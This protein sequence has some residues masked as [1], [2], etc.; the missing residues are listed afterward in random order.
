MKEKSALNLIFVF[1]GIALIVVTAVFV[2]SL[3]WSVFLYFVSACMIITAVV[4]MA[5]ISISIVT[6]FVA[7]FLIFGGWLDL[8]GS[9]S[10]IIMD[11]SGSLFW[12]SP[13]GFVATLIVGACGEVF[14]KRAYLKKHRNELFYQNCEEAGVVGESAAD[15]ARMKLVAEQMRIT[16]SEKELMER[17][18]KGRAILTEQQELADRQ[19]Q[20]AADH[21]KNMAIISLRQEEQKEDSKWKKII[22]LKGNEKRYQM[23]MEL[24]TPLEREIREFEEA[25]KVLQNADKTLYSAYA[26]K[27]SDW[28][29]HGG[30][31]NAIAG[32][33]AGV[34]AA[35]DVQRQNAEVRA[36]NQDLK[37]SIQRFTSEQ[38]K[39]LKTPTDVYVELHGLK[40]E[41]AAAK[42]KLVENRPQ[43]ELLTMLSPQLV[44]TTTT[45]TGTMRFE[46]STRK[47]ALQI[48]ETVQ[49]TVDGS[50]VLKIM[51]GKKVVGEAYFVLPIQGGAENQTLTGLCT[52]VP[53]SERKYSFEFAPYNLFA[54]ER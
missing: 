50:F 52:A 20:I 44:K 34:A 29:V 24:I 39:N 28:A 3:G 37:Q 6:L 18:R 42:L 27:E 36:Y 26:K 33:A 8:F 30:I 9:A 16:G 22:D 10:D 41:A 31:A 4:P 46:V 5:A 45:E 43:K 15:I 35:L 47:T 32:P 53:Q 17:Y 13:V 21:E 12:A 38:Q 23:Y 19:N 14:D 54:I 1:L 51:N 2:G 11:V 25:K 48:F 49:A 7:L 40:K